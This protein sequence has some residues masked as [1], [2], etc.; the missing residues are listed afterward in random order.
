[1]ADY[2][3]MLEK[4]EKLEETMI[5]VSLYNKTRGGGILWPICYWPLYVI[6]L[7]ELI[8]VKNQ[9]TTLSEMIG[10][11][12]FFA[13]GVF[14]T[15]GV[16]KQMTLMRRWYMQQSKDYEKMIEKN[17][18]SVFEFLKKKDPYGSLMSEKSVQDL[19]NSCQIFKREYFPSKED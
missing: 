3:E 14:L 8:A 11:T 17:I 5:K 7:Y 4:F 19:N 18:Q 9:I 12:V 6:F 16:F 13:I 2:Y 15:Y 1:M 10:V